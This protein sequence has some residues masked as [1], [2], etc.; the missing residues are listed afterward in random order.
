MVLGFARTANAEIITPTPASS[1]QGCRIGR[2][3]RLNIIIV[4]SIVLSTA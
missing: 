3:N 2:S 1:F 4:S